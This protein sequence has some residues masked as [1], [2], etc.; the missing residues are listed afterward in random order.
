MIVRID[1]DA[2]PQLIEPHDFKKFKIEITRPR[3]QFDRFRSQ[4]TGKVRLENSDHGWVSIEA[5]RTWQGHISDQPFQ[6]GLTSMIKVAE[7]YGW[8]DA[9]KKSIRAHIEWA[10]AAAGKT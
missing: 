5:L 8:L 1:Q 3:A 4:F 10:G 9:D 2:E 6:D 7:K